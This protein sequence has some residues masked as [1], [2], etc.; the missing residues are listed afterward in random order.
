M[1]GDLN[2]SRPDKNM[3]NTVNTVCSACSGSVLGQCRRRWTN[4]EPEL[5]GRPSG[6]IVSQNMV[7]HLLGA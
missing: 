5:G 6:T 1:V 3:P 7:L 4:I 2:T